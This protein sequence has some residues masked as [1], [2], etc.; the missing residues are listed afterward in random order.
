M[1]T[2]APAWKGSLQHKS[3]EEYRSALRKEYARLGSLRQA[4][5]LADKDSG[6]HDPNSDAAAKRHDEHGLGPHTSLHTSRPGGWKAWH[7]ND[8]PDDPR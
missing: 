8:V 5:L 1:P 7:T 2:Q 3:A 6:D 4:E